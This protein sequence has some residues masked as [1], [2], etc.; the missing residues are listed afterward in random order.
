[1]C[2]NILATKSAILLIIIY[3]VLQQPQNLFDFKHVSCILISQCSAVHDSE[4]PI[5]LTCKQIAKLWTIYDAIIDA[6]AMKK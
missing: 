5:L 6:E 2:I 3:I 1:M 4:Q